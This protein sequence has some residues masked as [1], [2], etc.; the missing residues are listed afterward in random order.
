MRVGILGAGAV[1]YGAAAR[2]AQLGHEATIWS[3]SGGRTIELALGRP[4]VATGAIT[5][6][7]YP[8]VASSC[9]EAVEDADTVLLAMPGYGHR[10]ALEA[11]A[12]YVR[13]NQPFIISSHMSFGAL[14]LSK[15][16]SARGIRAP[17]IAWGSTFSTGR[18]I[19]ST[20]VTVGAIRKSVDLATLPESAIDEGLALCSKLFGDNFTKSDGLL[21]I[22]LSN[23]NPQIHLGI[24]LLNLTRIERAEE[25]AQNENVTPTVGRL[26]EA[27]DNERLA[28][29]AAFDLR[30][31]TVQEHISLSYRIPS[32]GVSDMCQEMHRRGL[33]ASGPKT[34]DSR[35]VLEDVPFGLLPTVL[36]GKLSGRNAT[37][38]E[39]GIS[40]FSAAYG[41][42]FARENDILA[43]LELENMTVSQLQCIMRVGYTPF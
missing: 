13:D 29:A 17:I 5:G 12:P 31:R 26:I 2:L 42:H 18:Q 1:A 7:F 30:V 27:L 43:Q 38:H 14:Y 33:G 39:C 25:W 21:A 9:A 28:I 19:T 40:I 11:A 6:S 10:S 32:A 8:R 3:P 15:L 24:A 4:L 36:L 34:V 16:L 20:Q 35:Y 41:R 23:L 22:T 37:L